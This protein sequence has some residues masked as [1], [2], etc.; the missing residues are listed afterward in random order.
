MNKSAFKK[1]L[2]LAF[3]HCSRIHVYNDEDDCFFE[4][5][6]FDETHPDYD[7]ED[8]DGNPIYLKFTYDE[9]TDYILNMLPK[10]QS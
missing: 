4:A 9:Y 7:R 3:Y 2:I 10:E 5:I 6:I 8:A 1:F